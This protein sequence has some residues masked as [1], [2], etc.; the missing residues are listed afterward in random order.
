MT[1]T[2][3][4]MVDA[5]FDGDDINFRARTKIIIN[6]NTAKGAQHNALIRPVSVKCKDEVIEHFSCTLPS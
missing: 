6:L 2:N 3:K 4:T 5:Y 1:N